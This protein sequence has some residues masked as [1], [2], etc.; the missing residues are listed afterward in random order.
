MTEHDRGSRSQELVRGSKT[1]FCNVSFRYLQ[2]SAGVHTTQ[3][4]QKQPVKKNKQTSKPKKTAQIFFVISPIVDVVSLVVIVSRD[5][6]QFH[7]SKCASQSCRHVGFCFFLFFCKSFARVSVRLVMNCDQKWMADARPV[8][9]A[10][11]TQ[12]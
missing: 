12:Q 3:A 1:R 9:L 11:G 6:L 2:H 5:W 8:S 4:V 10:R 7:S